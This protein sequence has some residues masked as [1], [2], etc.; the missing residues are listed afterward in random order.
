MEYI[1]GELGN[2]LELKK[3]LFDMD[4][5]F[6]VYCYT[7]FE[8]HADL[9]L[10]HVIPKTLGGSNEDFNL[11]LAC[12]NCNRNK[13]GKNE[14]KLINFLLQVRRNRELAHVT[15]ET[16]PSRVLAKLPKYLKDAYEE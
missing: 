15:H 7:E 9:T 2:N 16:I 11:V 13:G 10:D 8:T 6:C 4:G 12:A 14:I 5:P 3:F 1:Y